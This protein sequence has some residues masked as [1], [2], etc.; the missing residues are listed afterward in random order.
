MRRGSRNLAELALT[1]I[2]RVRRFDKSGRG[3]GLPQPDELMGRMDA[4]RAASLTPQERFFKNAQAKFEAGH[5]AFAV[6][7]KSQ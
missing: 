3:R 2:Q 1:L 4:A 7:T 5:Y 6:D